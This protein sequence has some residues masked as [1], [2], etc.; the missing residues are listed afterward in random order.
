[1]FKGRD[2]YKVTTESGNYHHRSVNSSIINS[3][4]TCAFSRLRVRIVRRIPRYIFPY[5]PAATII[6]NTGNYYSVHVQRLL[7]KKIEINSF[8][9][10][11]N[12]CARFRRKIDRAIS[13]CRETQTYATLYNTNVDVTADI[14]TIM[15]V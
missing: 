13:F 5:R 12:T 9:C 6:H 3:F 11:Y 7:L 1:M 15:G 2:H 14:F 8:K 4:R 10:T